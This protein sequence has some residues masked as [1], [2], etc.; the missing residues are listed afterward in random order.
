MPSLTVNGQVH[1]L[2]PGST[3]PAMPLLWVLR[4]V[5]QLTGTKFGCGVAACGACT[6]HLGGQPVRSCVTPLSAAQGQSISTIEA[7]ADAAPLGPALQQAWVQHQVP[8]CGYCQSGMLMAAAALLQHNL[9]PS[10]ADID[11]AMT[12]LCRCGSYPRVRAAIH[13][14]AASLAGKPQG[15]DASRTRVPA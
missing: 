1:E 3:D 13:A 4:D 7:L 6:I 12:N 5:L 9:R 2:P 14:A 10:D 8:Q 15:G 11:A